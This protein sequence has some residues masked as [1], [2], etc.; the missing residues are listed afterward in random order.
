MIFGRLK[1]TESRGAILAHSLKTPGGTLRKG[2]LIDDQAYR[3]LDQAGYEH[4]TIARLEP[5]DITEQDAAAALGDLLQSPGLYR[6]P[7]VNGRVNLFAS[8]PG[9]LRIDR[10]AVTRLNLSS[11]AV[12]LATLADY[13]PVAKDDMVATLKIIPFAVPNDTL[14]RAE[15]CITETPLLRIRPFRP[16]RAGL[17]VT[18]LPQ[19]KPA[20]IAGT[21]EVT[22]GRIAAHGGTML[23]HLELPH[24]EAAIAGGI[25][26]LLGAKAELL[27]I[28]GASAVTDR[29][30]VAPQA[31]RLAGGA[32]SHFGMPVDPGNLICFG[33]VGDVPA[34][35]LP[36]CARSKALNGIDWVL[37]RVF[38]GEPLSEAEIA[39]M[40]AGG[41]L[42]EA[43]SR[44]APR[45]L[46]AAPGIGRS[47]ASPPRFAALVLAAG[48]STRMGRNKLL[49]LLPDGR[50]MIAHT[51]DNILATE[52]RPVIVVTGHQ[53]R[54]LRNA[55]GGRPVRFLHAP[56]HARGLSASLK[57]GIAAIA[58]DIAGVLICLGDMPLVAPETLHSLLA[59]FDPEAGH[60]II[61]P[62]FDGQRGNPI[63]WGR[64]FFPELQRLSGD[65]GARQ[66]LPEHAG[67][68][69]EIPA[70]DTV[71]RDFDTPEMLA[72]LNPIH[73]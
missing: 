10:E 37:D 21:V 19:L 66:I 1:L 55:L 32:V 39:A 36:G 33:N 17:I 13:S 52:A 3:L 71:L 24:E 14:A 67:V 35:I 50:P 40:G 57:A 25:R 63:L 69:A 9:L 48:S 56:D 18:L 30:D 45:A 53:D 27:L 16:L 31:I 58:S 22:A 38:A 59:G 28:A 8:V 7:V 5:G 20:T 51:V 29:Q 70:P 41:L 11:E 2:A 61:V 60:E 34:L 15:H 23:P 72:G 44:P 68:I 6:S 12:A 65:A 26:R 62:V 49:A 73:A 46:R 43:E 42:K 4:V 47:P 54:E 64:R